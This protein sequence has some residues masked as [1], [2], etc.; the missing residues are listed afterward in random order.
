MFIF[1][2]IKTRK[3]VY[4]MRHVVGLGVEDEHDGAV[5]SG[6]RG[7]RVAGTG[8]REEIWNVLF[9]SC[10]LTYVVGVHKI[11][12]YNLYLYT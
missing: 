2:K 4:G 9:V 8:T 10:K 6:L 11:G 12:V 3:Q 7:G 5:Y 1:Y